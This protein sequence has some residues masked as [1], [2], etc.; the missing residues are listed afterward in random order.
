LGRT[1]EIIDICRRVWRREVLT[2]DGIYTIPLPPEQGTGLAKPLKLIN[3][4]LRPDIPIYLASLGQRNVELTAEVAEGWLPIFFYPEKAANVWAAPLAAGQ[5][6][7]SPDLPPLDTVASAVVGIV[8]DA[9]TDAARAILDRGRPKLALYIGGMGARGTNFYN[10]LARRYGFEA[11]AEQVQELYLAGAKDEAAKAI[12]QEML[13]GTNIVGPEGY[14]KER[15]AAYAEAGVT[16]L[17]VTPVAP[18]NV[19]LVEQLRGWV[20]AL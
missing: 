9:D 11:E 20:D 13:Q 12:P 5:A 7:R 8:N 14:I 19:K 18:D 2:N 6:K 3:Q 16:T 1:R 10:D 4:P 15:L 17:N